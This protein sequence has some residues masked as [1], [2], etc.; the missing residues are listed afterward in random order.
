MAPP[1]RRGALIVV[2]VA[3]LAVVAYMTLTPDP[4]GWEPGTPVAEAID[5]LEQHT[6]T[7]AYDIIEALANVVMFVPFGIL[8]WL[9]LRRRWAAILVGFT[10][11]C[12][13]ELS[14]LAFLPTR[15][16]SVQDVLM[17]S[18]GAA[19]GV[20]LVTLWRRSGGDRSG[21]AER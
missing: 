7:D 5:W 13:I 21:V 11:S 18:L 16:A 20:A 6:Q 10:A 14:Q 12:C 17:N 4:Q 8:A 2:S 9:W 1:L 15:Y 3:Y 19:I